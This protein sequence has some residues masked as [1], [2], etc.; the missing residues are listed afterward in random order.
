MPEISIISKKIDK[1]LDRTNKHLRVKT[2]RL[3][4]EINLILNNLF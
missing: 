2:D 1:K 4:K 3:I